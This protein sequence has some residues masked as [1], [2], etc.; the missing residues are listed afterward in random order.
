M[1]RGVLLDLDDTLI[2]HQGAVTAALDRWLPDL[3]VASTPQTLALWNEVQEAIHLD[4]RDAGPHDE[5]D[6]LT[7]LDDLASALAVAA[8]RPRRG[9]SS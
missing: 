3:G 2:D 5:P 7:T 6:R 8:R 1:L 4:R 9:R